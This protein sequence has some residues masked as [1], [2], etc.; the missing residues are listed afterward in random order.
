MGIEDENENSIL[1]NHKIPCLVDGLGIKIRD[2]EWKFWPP[3]P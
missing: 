1:K 2:W 3:I